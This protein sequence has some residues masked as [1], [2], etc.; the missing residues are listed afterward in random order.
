MSIELSKNMNIE[1]IIF[2]FLE[3]VATIEEQTWV[4]NWLDESKDHQNKFEELKLYYRWFNKTSIDKNFNKEQ[5]WNRIKAGYYQ[6]EYLSELN[7]KKHQVKKLIFRILIPAAAAVIL[8]FIIGFYSSSR[9]SGNYF[10]GSKTVNN[11]VYVPLGSRSQITLSD[12]TMVWLNA[13]SRLTYPVNFSNESREVTLEGEAYFEVKKM[14]RKIFIVNTS[15]V[16]VKVYGTHFNLKSYPEENTI[17]ATLV[18]GSLSIEPINNKN[19]RKPVYLKPKQSVTYYKSLS[20]NIEQKNA[21]S[22][23]KD[24]NLLKPVQTKIVVTPTIDPLP[25]TS[26]KDREWVIVG[27]NLNDLAVKLERRYNVK[28]TFQDESLKMYKFTGT[29]KEETFEQ[30]LKIMQISAPLLFI[31]K[32]NN[33]IFKEDPAFRKKYDTMIRNPN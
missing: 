17:Q 18:E 20:P 3:G 11:A 25:I 8:A 28:I 22:S 15:D 24:R 9:L 27:E 21:Y 23:E 4:R 5:G 26:W 12:G 29:L 10:T 32:D 6:A 13:G 33:V 19:K 1:E 7:K 2:R 31:V 16:K 30:V 14:P